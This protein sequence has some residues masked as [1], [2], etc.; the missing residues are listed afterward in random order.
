MDRVS[1]RFG[2]LSLIVTMFLYGSTA[3][4]GDEPMT[5]LSTDR[6]QTVPS[7]AKVGAYYYPWYRGTNSS[8]QD[9]WKNVMRLHLI[10]P[11]EP[12]CG[13]YDSANPEVVGEHIAQSLCGGLDF[14]AVSWW[15][16]ESLTDTVFKDVI[17]KH[18]DAGKLKYAVL[19]ESTGRMG[20]FADPGYQYWISDLKYMKETYFSNP[21]YLTI[22]GRPVVF[23]YLTRE[24]F[25]N[26]GQDALKQMREQFPE[27]YLVGDDV[28][29]GSNPASGY[30]SEWA[31][32]FDAVTVYDVYGQ[33]IGSL[34]ATQKAIE[35]L[36]ANYRQAKTAANN[37]GV[38]FM[39]TIAPGYNDTAVRKGH[40]GRARYFTDVED[41]REGDVFREMIRQAALPNLDSTCDR[42]MLVTSFN[43]WF[44]DSQIEPTK[45]TAPESCTDDSE[46]GKYYTGGSVYRD[47]GTLYLDILKEEVK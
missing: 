26:K 14:W 40:P 38:G 45:G 29:F 44:E 43:E 30:K 8:R 35:F 47:Y 9:Q 17:L 19:Y 22:N 27:I 24:Y 21:N 41:S 6:I 36:A 46:D 3:V 32:N 37:V 31:E 7:A 15:G 12:L 1:Y 4:S 5:E 13:L 33:S 2:V 25:R 11:Q 28:F 34:G 10:P 23:V 18:P 42:M 39:P 20:S 16:P